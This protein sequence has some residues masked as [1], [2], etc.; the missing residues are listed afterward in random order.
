MKRT[1]LPIPQ[2]T[3]TLAITLQL[4]LVIAIGALLVSNV[5]A[6]N[7]DRPVSKPDPE[8]GIVQPYPNTIV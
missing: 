5:F 7:G 3:V 8:I 4:L 1:Q 2:M 6:Q